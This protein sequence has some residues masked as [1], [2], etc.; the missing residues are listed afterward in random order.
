MQW[1]LPPSYR[2]GKKQFSGAHI[3]LQPWVF[4]SH[5]ILIP[6]K[7]PPLSFL[8]R[9]F[10]YDWLEDWRIQYMKLLDFF[11]LIRLLKCHKIYL[12]SNILSIYKNTDQCTH[13][14]LIPIQ[15]NHKWKICPRQQSLWV[16]DGGYIIQKA[17][18]A[19]L[20]KR[21]PDAPRRDIKETIVAGKGTEETFH[22]TEEK[23]EECNQVNDIDYLKNWEN[24]QNKA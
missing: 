13:C 2:W 3:F 10:I 4:S 15:F 11:F 17:S 16:L 9:T 22:K 20:K 21:K 12:P 7:P 24:S 5:A 19:W 8:S 1:E 23:G 6:T 18:Q 14:F